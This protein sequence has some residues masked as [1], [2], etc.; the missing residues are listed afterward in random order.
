VLLVDS[1]HGYVLTGRDAEGD[2]RFPDATVELDGY[3]EVNPDDDSIICVYEGTGNIMDLHNLA[4][5]ADP[6]M[7]HIL[8]ERPVKMTRKEL[9]ERLG[10]T[11]EIVD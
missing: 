10:F 2:S 5:H 8:W 9:R 1:R 6:S 4:A 11:V 3:T 7:L